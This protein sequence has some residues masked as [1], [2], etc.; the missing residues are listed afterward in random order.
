MSS[1]GR[2]NLYGGTKYAKKVGFAYAKKFNGFTGR[3]HFREHGKGMKR[4]EQ[5]AGRAVRF[6]NK[7]GPEM[8]VF[9]DKRGS[10]HKYSR[11][12]G[13]YAIIDKRG[14]VITYYN[15]GSMK[16]FNNNKNKEKKG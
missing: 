12:T 5:Y 1:K 11:K 2:S 8:A 13:E 9:I 3:R 6:A 15:I 10:T 16:P 14:Y 4:I 7:L